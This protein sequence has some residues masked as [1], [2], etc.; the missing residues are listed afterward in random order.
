VRI[1]VQ[2]WL[3][4]PTFLDLCWLV[5]RSETAA[6]NHFIHHFEG[7][8]G[9]RRLEKDIAG[10]HM[11]GADEGPGLGFAGRVHEAL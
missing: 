11:T 9:I 4:G 1:L 7:I 3:F 2:N 6:C 10:C 5:H 8:R